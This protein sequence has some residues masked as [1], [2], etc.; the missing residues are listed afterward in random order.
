MPSLHVG[1]SALCAYAAWLALRGRH[2]RSAL[3]VWL[4]PVIMIGVLITTGAHFVV[5]VVGSAVLLTVSIAVAT[6]WDRWC[7]A[8]RARLD[9]PVPP[10][11]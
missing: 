1:W 11:Q 6:G 8:R 9:L 2:P 3:L 7:L 5:D 4:F 10:L